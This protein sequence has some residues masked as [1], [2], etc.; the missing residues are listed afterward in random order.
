M[1][2][3]NENND[4]DRGR[5]GAEIKEYGTPLVS[6]SPIH[7]VSIIGQIEGHINLPP[8]NKTTK[9]EHV[10]PQLVMIEQ[11]PN[12][13]GFILLMNTAGG[14][15]EAGLALAEMIA[16]M[17]KPSVS[18]VLGGGHSIGITLA[19]SADYSFISPTASVTVHPIRMSGLIIGVP[20]TFDYFNKM[21]QRIVR[22]VCAHA[23]IEEKEY[24]RLMMQTGEMAND[25]GTVLVGKEV[26]EHGIINE[27]GTFSVALQK[28]KSLAGI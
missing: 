26:V 14:D 4:A 25:C 13:K 7:V 6:S 27:I 19:V 2:N 3:N 22:F 17:S 8:H 1:Q 12:V 28:L 9:Y 15:V 21:Q 18:L 5:L 23:K 24:R 16:G 20:Q 11:D 10:L